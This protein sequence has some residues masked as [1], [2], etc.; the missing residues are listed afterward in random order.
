MPGR[1][2]RVLISFVFSPRH[3]RLPMYGWKT[4][5]QNG[6]QRQP[7]TVLGDCPFRFIGRRAGFPGQRL[8]SSPTPVP[9]LAHHD[10]GRIA[11]QPYH[12]SNGPPEPPDRYQSLLKFSKHRQPIAR[13][14]NRQLSLPIY[15]DRENQGPS[16]DN[17][18]H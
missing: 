5:N 12:P 8:W 18:G 4:T 13:L 7:E 15:R 2:P 17:L 14:N 9:S 10:S 16:S 1:V 11:G 3:G 6:D